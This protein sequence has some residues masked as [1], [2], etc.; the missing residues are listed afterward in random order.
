MESVGGWEEIEADG[1]TLFSPTGVLKALGG[2][3]CFLVELQTL[4]YFPLITTGPAALLICL[5][6][7][8]FLKMHEAKNNQLDKKRIYKR[9]K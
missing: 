2:E 6:Q 5:G 7:A 4:G 1:K 9:N 3:L 8:E